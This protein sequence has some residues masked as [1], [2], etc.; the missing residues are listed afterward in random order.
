MAILYSTRLFFVGLTDV[1]C[2]NKDKNVFCAEHVASK[3]RKLSQK[4]ATTMQLS[5]ELCNEK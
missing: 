5:V 4:S 1:Y 2:S 3:L